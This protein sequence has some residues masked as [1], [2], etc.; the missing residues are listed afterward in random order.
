VQ[1]RAIA[2]AREVGWAPSVSPDG[3]QLAY[4]SARSGEMEVWL[5]PVVDAPEERPQQLTHGLKIVRGD[6]I[7]WSPDSRT[8]AVSA[9][10]ARRYILIVDVATGKF[11]Q[12]QAP[13]LE[14]ADLWGALWSEDGRWVYAFAGFSPRRQYRIATG[15]VPLAEP[16]PGLPREDA[17]YENLEWA[18]FTGDSGVGLYRQHFRTPGHENS[19]PELIPGLEAV[20]P[21]INWQA[22]DGGLLFIDQHAAVQRLQRWDAKTGR[23]SDLTGPLSRVDFDF[24]FSYVPSKH[25]VV[26]PQYRDAAGTQIY[27]LV[28]GR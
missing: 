4:L 20:V 25:F 28:P 11:A 3:R 21:G 18:Y 14:G 22:A 17:F 19:Q 26:Y 16:I 6:Y 7:T 5:S 8:L 15:P 12:L 23:I 13:G 27:G 2:P 1:P 10:A 24:D 9:I